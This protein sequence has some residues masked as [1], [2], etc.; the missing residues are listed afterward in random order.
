MISQN[1]DEFVILKI[2]FAQYLYDCFMS[3]NRVLI[4]KIQFCDIANLILFVC[5]FFSNDNDFACGNSVS[6]TGIVIPQTHF[7]FCD[8][9]NRIYDIRK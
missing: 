8:I 6:N 5:F 4:S 9:T 7:L 2:A 3:H 1:P